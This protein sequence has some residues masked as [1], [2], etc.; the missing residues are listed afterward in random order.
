MFTLRFALEHGME[1]KGK[2]EYSSTVSS[3]SALDEGRWSEV[4]HGSFNPEKEMQ[5]P[6][7]RRLDG[8]Q[9]RSGGVQKILP[10]SGFK[11]RTVQSAASRYT[12]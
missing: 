10:S 1:Q 12:D 3:T 2:A 8:P 9:S 11:P 6:S 4:R 7:C 5:Y